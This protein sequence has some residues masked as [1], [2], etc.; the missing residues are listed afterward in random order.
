M[1]VGSLKVAIL[2]VNTWWTVFLGIHVYPTTIDRFKGEDQESRGSRIRENNFRVF[3]DRRRVET[4]LAKTWKGPYETRGEYR[5][6]ELFERT[7]EFSFFDTNHGAIEF[8]GRV[9]S[10]SFSGYVGARKKSLCGAMRCGTVRYGT[11][12]Y[13]TVR[14]GAERRRKGRTG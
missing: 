7:S 2:R 14:Y 8:Q 4:R 11:V 10:G 5:G 13:G 6:R 12:R 3:S 9:E 1:S